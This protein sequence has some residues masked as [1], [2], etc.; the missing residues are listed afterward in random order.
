MKRPR[1]T[2]ACGRIGGTDRR[3]GFSFSYVDS[4]DRR[5]GGCLQPKEIRLRVG[6]AAEKWAAGRAAALSGDQKERSR[7]RK[8]ELS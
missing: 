6:Q 2:T 4:R 1:E 3:R 5:K 7:G 8:E